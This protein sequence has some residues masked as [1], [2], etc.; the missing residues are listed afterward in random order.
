MDSCLIPSGPVRPS[1]LVPRHFESLMF[2]TGLAQLAATKVA[3]EVA[4][5]P[6]T[7]GYWDYFRAEIK[8]MVG[9]DPKGRPIQKLKSNGLVW[10]PHSREDRIR[11]SLPGC[12]LPIRVRARP[13]GAP[14]PDADGIVHDKLSPDFPEDPAARLYLLCSTDPKTDQLASTTLCLASGL[15]VHETLTITEDIPIFMSGAASLPR[16]ILS[17]QDEDTFRR[18][19][20]E[21]MFRG[22]MG[23]RADLSEDEGNIPD[24]GDGAGPEVGDDGEGGVNRSDAG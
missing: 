8:R 15:G 3:G 17:R 2:L 14:E 11:F 12:Q 19:G 20:E 21:D 6:R 13:F 7:R 5:L 9:P 18:Q 22:R 23:R 10:L 16:P 1:V 24:V 4:G